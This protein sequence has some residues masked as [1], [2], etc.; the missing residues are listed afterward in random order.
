MKKNLLLLLAFGMIFTWG[1]ELRAD[2]KP[3]LAILPFLSGKGIDQSRGDVCPI[4]GEVHRGG[5]TSHGSQNTLTRL[6]HQKMEE[7]GTFNVLPLE[8]V[9][10][11]FSESDKEQ[12][13]LNPVRSSL[14]IGK[15]S[16]ADYIF[17]GFVF[18]YEERV[19]SS[20]SMEKPASVGFDVH[21]FRLRDGKMIWTGGF[22]ETQKSLSENLFEIGS[23]IKGKGT[24]VTVE[25]FSRIGMDKI[26][27]KLP[28][29]KEMEE[30]P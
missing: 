5:N 1:V 22:D 7:K 21:L 24:W 18:R 30:M 3:R 25:E 12:F 14:Q 13:E 17:V 15:A 16:K 23:F 11:A 10:E 27:S 28:G 29:S 26:L 19:G 6:L 20:L 8:K 2:E 9:E 4:C